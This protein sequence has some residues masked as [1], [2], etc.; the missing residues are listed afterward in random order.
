MSKPNLIGN[1]EEKI[2]RQMVRK[3]VE[4]QMNEYIVGQRI[5][6]MYQDGKMVT[7]ERK[8]FLFKEII[9]EVNFPRGEIERMTVHGP[10]NINL[11]E[12]LIQSYPDD[13]V[14]RMIGKLFHLKS[15]NP[16]HVPVDTPYAKPF[17][18]L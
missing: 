15:N 11:K 7:E 5:K 4:R 13:F 1:T 3:E 8:F 17:H 18:M 10:F 6:S 16:I 12:G 14:L 2:L 9:D